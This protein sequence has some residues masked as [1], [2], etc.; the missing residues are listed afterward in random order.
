MNPLVALAAVPLLAGCTFKATVTP[1]HPAAPSGSTTIKVGHKDEPPI[2]GSG[3]LRT[4]TRTVG[5][6]RR[7]RLEGVAALKVTVGPA[8]SLQIEADDNL[9]PII[10]TA[11]QGETLVV[12]ESRSISTKHGITV[13]VTTPELVGIEQAGAGAFDVKGVTGDEFAIDVSGVGGVLL[14]GS[15]KRMKVDTSGAAGIGLSGLDV[16]IKGV[17]GIAATG[18]AGQ[19][20]A[21]LSGAGALEAYDL[22]VKDAKVS[23]SGVGGARVNPSGSLDASV[24]GIGGIVYRGNPAS[25]KKDVSGLGAVVPE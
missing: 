8:V 20:E 11:V 9:L 5:A 1:Q 25:L 23:V 16:R 4:E 18:R 3:V 14:A 12:S 21:S 7:I 22:A 19:L 17:G 2:A 10:A 24:S 6:F 15:A 13:T